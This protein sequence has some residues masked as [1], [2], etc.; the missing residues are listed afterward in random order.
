MTIGCQHPAAAASL[1]FRELGLF[2]QSNGGEGMML[3]S[4]LNHQ[5]LGN[6]EE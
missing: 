3:G 1:S 4:V 5:Y 6:A 2:L